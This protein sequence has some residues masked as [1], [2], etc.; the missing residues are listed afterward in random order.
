MQNRQLSMA[1]ELHQKGD[2]EKALAAYIEM[3][4]SQNPPLNAFLNAS[5]ILRNKEKL[6][7]AVKYLNV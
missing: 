7:Q 1:V 4:D 5:S 6:P 3:L 2:L